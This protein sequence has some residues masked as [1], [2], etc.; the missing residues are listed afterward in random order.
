[1]RFLLFALLA[2]WPSLAAAQAAPDRPS[3][4]FGLGASP[5]VGL[6]AA[7]TTPLLTFFARDV[8]LYTNYVPGSEGQVLLAA[9]AGVGVRVTRVLEVTGVLEPP[10]FEVDAGF[11]FGPA[12]RFALFEQSAASKARAFRLFGDPYIRVTTALPSG[13]RLFAEVGP[14]APSFRVGLVIVP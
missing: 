10:G 12:F 4:Q 3:L 1:M 9:G 5:G 13:R 11:R 7:Q 2:C 6:F 14:H 8:A